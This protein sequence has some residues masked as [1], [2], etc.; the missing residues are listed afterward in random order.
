[1]RPGKSQ[2]KMSLDDKK[3]EN[4]RQMSRRLSSPQDT[5][6]V[7]DNPRDANGHEVANAGAKRRDAIPRDAAIR[8]HTSHRWS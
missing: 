1:M 8:R 3:L 6:H 2:D 5:I 7:A 4:R